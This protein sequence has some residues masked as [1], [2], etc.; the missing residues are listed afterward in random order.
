MS[1]VKIPVT[2]VYGG[3]S[4]PAMNIWHC[5]TDADAGAVTLNAE[6]QEVVDALEDFYTAIKSCYGSGT[7]ITIG[8]TPIVDP[9]GS[10][11]Y[12]AVTPAVVQGSRP[13]GVEPALL[14][15]T[16][17]WRTTAATK[18]GR[19]RTFLGPFGVGVAD[20]DG[21]VADTELGL[22]RSAASALVS[23]SQGPNLWA[24]GVYSAKENLLRD[25]TSYAVRDQFATMRSR[26]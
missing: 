18:S 9:Y 10:P 22:M 12:A 24:L 20:S 17:T 11:T 7:T 14:A 2:I 1:T 15:V 23:A 8:E 16:V 13:G 25:F 6:V 5:R 26:R 3:G 19:G 21:S 4:S